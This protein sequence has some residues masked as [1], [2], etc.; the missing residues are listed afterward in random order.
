MGQSAEKKLPSNL[1][2]ALSACDEDAFPNIHRLLLTAHALSI[3]AGT[4][5]GPF[6]AHK[7]DQ[8]LHQINDV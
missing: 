3:V 8:D 1:L 6:F 2:L 7:T 5:S 4:L